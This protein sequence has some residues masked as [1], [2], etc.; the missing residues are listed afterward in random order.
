M[1]AL[2]AQDESRVEEAVELVTLESPEGKARLVQCTPSQYAQ[3][4]PAWKRQRN[5]TFCGLAS[6]SILL[7]ADGDDKDED[8]IIGLCTLPADQRREISA[9][10]KAGGFTLSALADVMVAVPRLANVIVHHADEIAGPEALRTLMCDALASARRVILN[11]H[12]S[13]IGQVS[14]HVRAYALC[15]RSDLSVT[16]ACALC[17]HLPSDP[18]VTPKH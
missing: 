17:L 11:Y 6:I 14:S 18:S 7:R 1:N 3:L 15:L 8:D 2:D 4:G 5:M 16:P 12:M 13:T 9:C 10:A